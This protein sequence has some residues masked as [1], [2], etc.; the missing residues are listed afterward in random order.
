MECVTSVTYV[1]MVNGEQRGYI[2]P[3]RG[4]RQGDP[5]SPYLFLICAEGLLALFRKA[6]RVS[7]NRIVSIC[8]GG[9]RVSHLFFADDSIILCSAVRE[10]C[11][12]LLSL[13]S[14]NEDTSSQKVNG[15]KTTLFF[16]LNTSLASH[17]AILGLF[18]TTTTIQFEKYLG[19]PPIIGRAKKKAFNYIK[20]KVGR[21]LQGWKEK[22]L[23]Q[24][25]HEVLTKAVIQA[26]LT[27]AMNCFK[28]PVRL[29]SEIS[30]MANRF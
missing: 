3:T 6:E 15:G 26:I 21:R 24:A 1:V 23:S 10:E 28:F 17:D 27:Y 13:L 9:P 18:G 12:N 2:K 14:L 29:C 30:A 19:L 22:L 20:D 7:L 5:L 25:G 4:L 16:H 11:E 8:K